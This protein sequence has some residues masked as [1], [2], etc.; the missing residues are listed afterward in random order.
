MISANMIACSDHRLATLV[1]IDSLSS[2]DIPQ[3]SRATILESN[4]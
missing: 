4:A 3:A 1:V 2:G